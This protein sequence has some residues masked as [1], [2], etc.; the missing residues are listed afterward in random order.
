MPNFPPADGTGTT[1]HEN[2]HAVGA[3]QCRRAVDRD[4]KDQTALCR[5]IQTRR[6]TGNLGEIPD[7][8][9]RLAWLRAQATKEDRQRSRYKLVEEDT[10]PKQTAQP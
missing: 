9:K 5:L 4:P 2:R 10:Q 8:L 3:E 7:L 1:N 6:K